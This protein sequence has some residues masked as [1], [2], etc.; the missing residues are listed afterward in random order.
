MNKEALMKRAKSFGWRAGMMAAALVVDFLLQ[1]LGDFNM[2]P[3]VTVVLG[4]LLGEVSKQLN[5]K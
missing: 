5:Q 3:Q 4:L 1:S 2:G